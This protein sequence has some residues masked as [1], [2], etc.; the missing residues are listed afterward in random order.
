[1]LGYFFLLLA[2]ILSIPG[3]G[4]GKLLGLIHPSLDPEYWGKDEFEN[5]IH[6]ILLIIYSLVIYVPLVKAVVC[7]GSLIKSFLSLFV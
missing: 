6:W 7:I 3:Y 4:L 2:F 5:L 1:M